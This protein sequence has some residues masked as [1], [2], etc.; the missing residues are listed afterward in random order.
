MPSLENANP[1]LILSIIL[2]VGGGGGIVARRLH[3]PSITGNILAGAVLG[4][5]LFHG[6]GLARQLA[7]LSTFAMGLIAASVGSHLSY[8]RIHNALRRILTIAILEVTCSVTFVAIGIRLTGG[9]WAAALL[10]GSLA[11]ATA[12]ATTLALVR[13]NR[14]KG[15][16]VKTLLSVV[17]VDNILCLI[18]F[19]FVRT[20]VA[21]EAVN[22]ETGFPLSQAIYSTFGQLAGAAGLGFGFGFLTA[23]LQP[24][25]QFQSFS[26]LFVV[27]LLCTGIA[28]FLNLSP[29]LSCLFLGMYLSNSTREGER[30]L[31][32]LG[33][34]E[35]LLMI[36]FFTL[37]GVALHWDMLVYAGVLC[38]LY[39]FCR[40]A[41]KVFGAVLGGLISRCSRRIWTNIP[42][43]LLPQAGLA[44][45]LVVLIEGD[46][47]IAPEVS[48]LVGTVVLAAVTI[49][50]II[51]PL[52]TRA[53]LRRAG[54][55]GLDRPRLIEFLQEEFIIT[56][57]QAD[58]KWSALKKLTDFYALTHH[59]RPK[60]AE[61]LYESVAKREREL[62]TAIGLGAAIPHG[63]VPSGSAVGGVLAISY[64]GIDFDAPDGQPVKIIMLIVT[65][66]DHEKR[67]LEVLASLMRML[68]NHA[69]RDRLA[70][71][72]SPE[73]AWE[74]IESLESRT[75]NYFLESDE[76]ED[77]SA[78]QS[79]GGQVSSG[80]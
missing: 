17:A 54:E 56:G 6:A 33:P 40:A 14:S 32:A 75:Y 30:E 26:T 43:A 65:P 51:G 22:P 60:D 76:D 36:S 70:A 48:T 79:K 34:L 8:R 42:M 62:T 77:G 3:I 66:R 37:A 49:N 29:L 72:I 13:E 24:K 10:L 7:P 61:P 23:H 11:A 46:T 45:G 69:F 12:P 67:H 47:R 25:P 28:S 58:D 21:T 44:V 31:E 16:F 9:S 15:P 5:T 59:L 2:L 35:P 78:S 55:A 38:A 27:I 1:L 80:H 74:I 20:A 4:M 63:R 73:D 53:A 19:A 50:E 52:F 39:F 41:G 68:S 71:A 57:L 18:V 64:D